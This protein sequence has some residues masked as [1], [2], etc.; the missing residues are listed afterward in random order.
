M[1]G[2]HVNHTKF[3]VGL[4]REVG[5]DRL[6]VRFDGE[7]EDRRFPLER[8]AEFLDFIPSDEVPEGAN[9]EASLKT[10]K[11]PA[12]RKCRMKFSRIRYAVTGDWRSCARC[13][14]NDGVQHVYRKYPESFAARVAGDGGAEQARCQACRNGEAPDPDTAKRCEDLKTSVKRP[15]A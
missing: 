5:I 14:A 7:A 1:A 8:A 2:D 10:V 3:G 15:V 11:A 6:L 9:F 4:I 12:C 13:S